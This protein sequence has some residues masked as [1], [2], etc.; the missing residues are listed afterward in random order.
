MD[1]NVQS[2]LTKALDK[3]TD[4]SDM[5]AL[6][7]GLITVIAVDLAG[8]NAWMGRGSQWWE[9]KGASASKQGAAEAMA[10]ILSMLSQRAAT[11]TNGPTIVGPT[12][13]EPG[14]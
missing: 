2:A 14:A 5:R 3:V 13:T 7:E 12:N 9:S 1:T 6:C 8:L 4:P 11:K 10:L